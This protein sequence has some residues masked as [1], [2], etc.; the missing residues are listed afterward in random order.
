[1]NILNKINTILKDQFNNI[2]S[3]DIPNFKKGDLISVRM[4]TSK[5]L[6]RKQIFTGVCVKKKN[7]GICSSF[8]LYNVIDGVAIFKTFPMY[9]TMIS[10]VYI[11]QKNVK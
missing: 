11:L 10:N 4:I 1:M 8:T 9:S 5:K 6:K 2:G 3:Y 7:K